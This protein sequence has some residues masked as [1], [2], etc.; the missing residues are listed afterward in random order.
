[1][2]L[3][4]ANPQD[5]DNRTKKWDI[6]NSVYGHSSVKERLLESQFGKCAFCESNVASVSHGDIEHYRPKKYWIQNNKIG[7]EGP[8]YYWL[9]YNYDNLIFACQ[10]CNQ[11]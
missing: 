1:N 5:Y 7:K 10:V 3:Y 2:R 11:N 9:A 8:G 6:K 4:D